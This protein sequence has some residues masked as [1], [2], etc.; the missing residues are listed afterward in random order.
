M[1]ELVCSP[2]QPPPSAAEAKAFVFNKDNLTLAFPKQRSFALETLKNP[3]NVISHISEFSHGERVGA[4]PDDGLCLVDR[5]S[6]LFL[7][8]NLI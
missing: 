3:M 8:E 7:K 1:Y 2:I 4:G 5:S 6:L